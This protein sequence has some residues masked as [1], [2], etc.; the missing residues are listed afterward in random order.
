MPAFGSVVTDSGEWD[1]PQSEDNPSRAR[2]AGRV[3]LIRILRPTPAIDYH[4][5][6]EFLDGAE[7]TTEVFCGGMSVARVTTSPAPGTRRLW[8]G[9]VRFDDGGSC[10]WTA[11]GTLAS[12]P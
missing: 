12:V 11:V 7:G 10:T 9:T 2:V 3:Q 6:V 8:L 5:G 4:V 1:A